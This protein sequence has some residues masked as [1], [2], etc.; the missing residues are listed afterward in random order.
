MTVL[1]AYLLRMHGS[2]K[3]K[4]PLPFSSSEGEFNHREQLD[5]TVEQNFHSSKTSQQSEAHKTLNFQT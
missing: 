4:I 2:L 3:Y 1:T 5:F